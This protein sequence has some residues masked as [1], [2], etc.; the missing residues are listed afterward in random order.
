MAKAEFQA[1]SDKIIFTTRTNGDKIEIFGVHLGQTNAENLAGLVN[2]GET[3][4]V[5]IKKASE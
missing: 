4:T 1:E 2:S 3:L 5:I